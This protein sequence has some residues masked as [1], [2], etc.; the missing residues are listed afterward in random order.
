MRS[1]PDDNV[2]IKSGK[3]YIPF[4]LRLGEHYL[5]DGIWLVK[6]T[7]VSSSTTNVDHY[8]STLYK[9]ADSPEYID[10]PKLCSMQHYTDYVLSHPE[11]KKLMSKPS[12]IT[13]YVAKT[14]ALVVEL[15]DTLKN[16]KSHE[17]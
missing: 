14:I 8:I 3:R 12:S 7:D 11:F 16:K 15:N 17:S 4:G 2:Y 13:D 10:I 9:V 6:H 5:P 1:V